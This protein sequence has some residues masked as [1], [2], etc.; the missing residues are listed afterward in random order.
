MTSA[1]MV[2]DVMGFMQQLQ[3]ASGI[4][5]ESSIVPN[6]LEMALQPSREARAILRNHVPGHAC[7]LVNEAW[8]HMIGH[9][10]VGL[11]SGL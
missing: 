1:E 10:Q 6:T 8:T 5:P 9:T 2:F 7:I 3:R 4:S 11:Y